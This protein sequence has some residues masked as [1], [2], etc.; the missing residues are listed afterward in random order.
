MLKKQTDPPMQPV[1]SHRQGIAWITFRE[2]SAFDEAVSRRLRKKSWAVY[3]MRQNRWKNP[4]LQA[5][6]TWSYQ[7]FNPYLLPKWTNQITLGQD[8]PKNNG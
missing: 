7:I 4:A 5:E 6:G 8:I 1:S 2:K 3:I